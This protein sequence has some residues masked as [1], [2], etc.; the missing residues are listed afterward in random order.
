MLRGQQAMEWHFSNDE[1][2]LMGY[3]D[4]DWAG[5]SEDMKSTSGYLFSFGS[6]AFT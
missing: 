2:I 4:S 3:C 5:S 1:A 6:G